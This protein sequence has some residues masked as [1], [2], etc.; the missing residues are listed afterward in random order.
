M[1]WLEVWEVRGASL[2]NVFLLLGRFLV[3]EKMLYF[4]LPA[5]AV[6]S[7]WWISRFSKVVCESTAPPRAILS[8]P[9][10]T[11]RLFKSSPSLH[12]I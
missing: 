6:C 4:A 7:L 12:E 10:G 2:L 11:P 5:F 9:I 3:L 1:T 8:L